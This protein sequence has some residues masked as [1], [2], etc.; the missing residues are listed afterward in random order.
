M[1]FD[2]FYMEIFEPIKVHNED[3]SETSKIKITIEL[4]KVIEKMIVK[5]PGQWIW[6]HNRWK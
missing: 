1:R 5:D 6:T 3:K 4:N 2:G